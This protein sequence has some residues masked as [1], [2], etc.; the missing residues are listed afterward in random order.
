MKVLVTGGGGFIGSNLVRKLLESGHDVRVLD[1]FSTGNRRNLVDV[2]DEIEIVEG[3]LRSY[4]RV[5]NATRGV[6]VVFHQGAL[7]S[8]PRSMQD[9]LTTSAVNVEGTLNVLLAARDEDV[10]RV[11]FA[12]SSSVYGNTGELPRVESQFPDPLSPYAVSK[13]AAER[14]CVTF[15]RVY[16]LETVT[17]RYFNVFGPRQDPTSQYAAV[18]PRFM[19]AIDAG[20]PVPIYGDGEQS[21]D[22]TYVDNVVEAN[23]LAADARDAV[24]AVLNIAT[25]RSQSVNGL[26][27]AIGDVLGK[28]VER[29]Y[30]GTRAGDVRDSW[31]DVSEADRLLGW[32]PRVDL[33]EGLR[34]AAEAFVA[35]A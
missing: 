25:G 24:G 28:T 17:L 27:D 32:K 11:V 7:P 18:V 30:L 9:P 22:F 20:E 5:H 29:E 1:N 10:R 3:E 31:A 13:L 26:A 15:A 4:E 35:R 16:G 19:A 21:R 23:L 33:E 14:Y 8:V 34:L 6:E 12:S 2:V